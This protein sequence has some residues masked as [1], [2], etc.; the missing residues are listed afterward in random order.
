MAH[1]DDQECEGEEE[2]R[3]VSVALAFAAAEHFRKV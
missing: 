2:G 3:H 1:D